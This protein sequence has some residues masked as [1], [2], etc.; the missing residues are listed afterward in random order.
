VT[1]PEDYNA[2]FLKILGSPGIASKE[3][4]YRQYDHNVR[5][6]TVLRPGA[7]DAGVVRVLVGM[8]AKGVAI[9]TGCNARMVY[10]DPYKGTMLAVAEAAC[11]VAAV[12]AEP[13]AVT[14]CLN[15][16]NPEKP[17][18]MW[19]FVESVRGLGDACRGFDTPVVSG[20]VSLYNE[21]DGRAIHPT[22]M[23]G[24]VGVMPDARRAMTQF[25]RHTGD[26]V[27]LVG[28]NVSALGG[29]EYL[30]LIHGKLAGP[31]PDCDPELIRYQLNAVRELIRAQMLHSCHDV[32]D[33]GLAIALAE[34]CVSGPEPIGVT[35]MIP[36]YD[37]RADQM[38]FSEP[39]GRFIVSFPEGQER[40]VERVVR[41][42]YGQFTVLGE[43]GGDR[44]TVRAGDDEIDLPLADVVKTWRDGFRKVAG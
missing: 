43:V 41:D 23:I 24:M 29:S 40:D 17:E 21:T 39:P 28:L 33:G 6:G 14:D 4:V 13:L 7:A 27:A 18:I 16:G 35:A 19:Q 2:A 26:V 31:V 36:T 34:A 20:N 42:C 5:H 9:S 38:L 15:F 37:M 32:S 1:P 30:R 22:P 3:W 10:L 12:G 44:F 8:R 11:N 25:F